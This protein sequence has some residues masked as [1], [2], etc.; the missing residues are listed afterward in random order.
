MDI[1][2]FFE[3]GF[4]LL[5]AEKIETGDDF[6]DNAALPF[7][8]DR[9]AW[10]NY[11]DDVTYDAD[12]RMRAWMREMCNDQ[13]W[14]KGY[15]L[16]RYMYKQLFRILYGREYDYKTDAKYTYKLQR[17]FAYYSSSIR[18]AAKNDDGKWCAKPAYIISPKRL[19]C[20]PYSLKLRYEEFAEQGIM[21]DRY[22][23][24]VPKDN[25]ATGHARNPQIDEAMQKR[26]QQKRERYNEYQR[27]RNSN[28]DRT[29]ED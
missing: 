22:N 14:V 23:M 27:A 5:G 9:K 13:R 4:D 11:T 24:A 2:S 19:K 3:N 26:K 8:V 12:K 21:P 15:K 18:T 1:D 10:D 25:L 7:L 17:V 28:L 6:I 20:P 29:A 16:R